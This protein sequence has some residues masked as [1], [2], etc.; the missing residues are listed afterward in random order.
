[1][2]FANTSMRTAHTLASCLLC[3]ALLATGACKKSTTSPQAQPAA[4]TSTVA[5]GPAPKGMVWI[6]PGS[7]FMGSDDP[8]FSDAQPVHPVKLA[9]F[10]MDATEVTNA[11]F[12]AFVEATG[13]QTIAEQTPRPEDFP[14]APPEALVAGSVA[15]H[16]PDHDVPLDDPSQWWTYQPGVSWQ[17]PEGP[18]SSIAER[19][20]HPVVHVAWTDA[21]A[22]CK[23]M[24]KRLPTEAEWEYAARGGLDRKRFAWGDDPKPGNKWV[25]NV[26]QGRFPSENAAEDGF[27]AT[28]PVAH[29]QAN[30]YGLYDVAGNVWEWTADLYHPD[31]Y[32]QS[33]AENPLGPTQAHDPQEPGVQKRVMRGGSF[34]CSDLY[35]VRYAVGAR[36]KGAPD[37]GSSHLGFRCVQS[38]N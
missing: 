3:G 1:M 18:A 2:A 6:P 15:F 29:Y 35:C 16:P 24:N 23:W 31:Y 38:G 19:L 9:G 4:A 30:A 27:T 26:W 5:P 11:D 37:T 28:A 10:W 34:L 8:M 32:K 33:P 12:K 22:F 36:G 7:F 13:F 21:A 25:A 14:Q 17:H 20:N